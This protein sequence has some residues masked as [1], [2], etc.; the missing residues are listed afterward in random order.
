M[1]H[2]PEHPFSVQ[3]TRRQVL[4]A[5][6]TGL[7]AAAAVIAG[8]D[9]LFG[10]QVVEQSRTRTAPP[11]V[12]HV[13]EILYDESARRLMASQKLQE[14]RDQL[15]PGYSVTIGPFDPYLGKWRAY[16][17]EG[18]YTREL[19]SGDA[20]LKHPSLFV[21]EGRHVYGNALVLVRDANVQVKGLF[22]AIS[23]IERPKDFKATPG[24]PGSEA[25][26]IALE[27]PTFADHG[28]F[29]LAG[30]TDRNLNPVALPESP[31]QFAS[32]DI[33]WP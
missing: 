26:T 20:E 1:R 7:T 15:P 5:A 17:P 3:M 12:D 21:Q 13:V 29:R 33:D 27:E 11:V 8:L 9:R 32:P 30:Y 2:S 4:A 23:H 14:W 24:S 28:Y 19:P 18:V 10:Q 16:D 6:A 31:N 25:E 22:I